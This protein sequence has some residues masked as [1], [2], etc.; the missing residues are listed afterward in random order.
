MF[1]SCS[2][3]SRFVDTVETAQA[4]LAALADPAQ[5]VPCLHESMLRQLRGAAV[6]P[7]R[8]PSPG[9]TRHPAAARTWGPTG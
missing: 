8:S 7:T 1:E 2:S 5:A 4:D 9:S 6:E 3:G